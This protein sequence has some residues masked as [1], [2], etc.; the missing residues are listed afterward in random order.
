MKCNATKAAHRED[1][2]LL[3]AAKK[4]ENKK[5]RFT[6]SSLVWHGQGR[7]VAT[8]VCCCSANFVF[9]RKT[10]L[11]QRS[12]IPTHQHAYIHIT[13]HALFAYLLSAVILICFIYVIP[14]H[15]HCQ[16]CNRHSCSRIFSHF[17]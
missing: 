3:F 9:G 7:F 4:C 16:C 13:V 6:R 2:K 17:T 12:T 11:G 14:H 1:N 8:I 15:Q 10:G 5:H